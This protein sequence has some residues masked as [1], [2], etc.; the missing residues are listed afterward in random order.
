MMHGHEKSDSAIV[1]VKLGIR[2]LRC[3]EVKFESIATVT[4]CPRYFR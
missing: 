2:L 4:G 1:A 3:S